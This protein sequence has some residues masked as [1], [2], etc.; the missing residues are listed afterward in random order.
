[1]EVICK[2]AYL[3]NRNKVEVQLIE[4][5]DGDFNN[6]I[7][8]LFMYIV[9]NDS[10]RDYRPSSQNTHVLNCI[11]NIYSNMEEQDTI[12]SNF[13][14]I[15]NRFLNKEIDAQ[16]SVKQ[17]NTQ[18]RTGSLVQALLYNVEENEYS[19]LVAKVDHTSYFNE[20]DFKMQTGFSS[21]Q[22][23]LWKTCIFE[24][25][26]DN[27][28]IRIDSAKVHA[29]KRK[30]WYKEFLELAELQT[31]EVNTVRAFK[32]I[33]KLL[34]NTLKT[35][36]PADYMAIRNKVILDLRKPQHIDYNNMIDSILDD[37]DFFNY[38]TNK[39]DSLKDKLYKLPDSKSFD[40]Q[41]NCIPKSIK[42]RMLKRSFVVT[43][44]IELNVNDSIQNLRDT[45]ST[46]VDSGTGEKYL[47]INTVNQ[48]LLDSFDFSKDS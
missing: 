34:A 19:Y 39:I 17:L 1:M 5:E 38:P 32:S 28:G 46:E 23:Q 45:V 6:Y 16:A 15:A 26:F 12:Y 48:T 11:F 37:Y 18:I 36:A 31:D 27:E 33:D 30:Y 29:V 8:E 44:G 35:T 2:S 47:K 10:T 14:D 25:S 42:A 41:F 24:L 7:E 20:D 22:Q 3:I 9:S 40:R 13:L 43:P 4:T 21:E